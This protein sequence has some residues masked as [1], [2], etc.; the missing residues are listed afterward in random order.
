MCRHRSGRSFPT[1]R[2]SETN[3]GHALRSARCRRAG[4]VRPGAPLPFAGLE[5][6]VMTVPAESPTGDAHLTR[7]NAYLKQRNAQL[8]EDVT[9]LS[10]EVERLRQ[11]VARL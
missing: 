10:A 11:I 9:A 8:Q 4:R 7:E 3:H 6:P 2:P 5:A 1:R